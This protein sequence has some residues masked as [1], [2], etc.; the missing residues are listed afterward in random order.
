MLP[1]ASF[2]TVRVTV[3]LPALVYLC[4]G[5]LA[6]DVILSPKF[7]DH[8]VGLS[9]LLSVNLTVNGFLTLVKDAEKK[10]TGV[11]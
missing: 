1:P 11:F 7:Q 6:V 9:V 2:F 3:Y 5:F 4:V 8:E 10:A